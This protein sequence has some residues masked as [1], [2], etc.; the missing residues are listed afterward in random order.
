MPRMADGVRAA[1]SGGRSPGSCVAPSA[2]RGTV[3]RVALVVSRSFVLRRRFLP[4][5]GSPRKGRAPF[6][7]AGLCQR[8]PVFPP[9]RGFAMAPAREQKTT[10]HEDGPWSKDGIVSRLQTLVAT[11]K[12]FSGIVKIL[13]HEFGVSLSKNAVISKAHRNGWEHPNRRQARAVSS[14]PPKRTPK[15]DAAIEL[16]PEPYVIRTDL[17]PAVARK[18]FLQLGRSDCRWPVGE[19]GTRS[20]GFCGQERV[21]GKPYCPE[22]CN[23]AYQAPVTRQKAKE[24]EFA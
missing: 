6:L 3:P 12:A 9:D 23:R 5:L 19:P 20:F 7:F 14:L 1:F 21:P 22:C 11:G 16:R 13:N 17:P 4:R 8:A 2:P 10:C 15:A 24:T 18:T